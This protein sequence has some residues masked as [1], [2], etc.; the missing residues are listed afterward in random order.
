VMCL[1][2]GTTL[3]VSESPQADRERAFIRQLIAQGKT[4]KQIE[5]ALVAQY[6]RG[7]LATPADKGF[8]LAVWIVPGLA[9]LLAGT[10]IGFAVVRWRRGRPDAGGAL[11]TVGAPPAGDGARLRS[12]LERYDL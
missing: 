12:D 7:V 4:K 2:C 1:V 11:A 9:V 5:N 10:A 3:N 8:D 6:G